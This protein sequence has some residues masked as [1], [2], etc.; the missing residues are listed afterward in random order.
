MPVFGETSGSQG[1]EKMPVCWV[2]APCSLA[3]VNRRFRGTC[4]LHLQ[5]DHLLNVA[6]LLPDYNDA[7]IHRSYFLHLDTANLSPLLVINTE[8]LQIRESLTDS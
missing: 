7:E 1:S 3:E 5:G 8:L 6:K 2:V 4:C